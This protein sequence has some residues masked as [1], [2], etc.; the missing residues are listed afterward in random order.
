MGNI[1]NVFKTRS[2]R[3]IELTLSKSTAH[4]E[5]QKAPVNEDWAS[6]TRSAQSAK[7]KK[8]KD[9]KF[10]TI[11]TVGY[12]KAYIQQSKDSHLIFGEKEKGERRGRCST[13]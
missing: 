5:L 10:G 1:I 4:N 3:C 6:K 8:K 12:P 13:P 7:K 11:R 2:L 9:K